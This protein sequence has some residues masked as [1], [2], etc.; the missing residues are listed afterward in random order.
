MTSIDFLIIFFWLLYI[1]HRKMPFL[2]YGPWNKYNRQVFFLLGAWSVY[3]RAL[4]LL[5]YKDELL[6]IFVLLSTIGIVAIL[7]L[8]FI[9]WNR[10]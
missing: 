2:N 4:H 6:P 5:L 1:L 8:T 9:F 7:I 10:I 3:V